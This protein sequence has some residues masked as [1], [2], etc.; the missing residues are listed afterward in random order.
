MFLATAKLFRLSS[1]RLF[2]DIDPNDVSGSSSIHFRSLMAILTCIGR[3]SAKNANTLILT[4][5]RHR[6]HEIGLR[7]WRFGWP[8][9]G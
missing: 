3:E 1:M 6:V 7:L 4:D 5:T 9:R 2:R 8:L